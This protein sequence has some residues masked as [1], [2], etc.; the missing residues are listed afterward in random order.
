LSG[1]TTS[2]TLLGQVGQNPTNEAA[3]KRFV[4]LYAPM[5]YQWILRRGAKPEDAEDLTQMVFQRL[6]H[7]MAEF[8]YDR[9][10]GSFKGWLRTVTTNVWNDFRRKKSAV[11][12]QY[13][14][15]EKVPAANG[16]A[17]DFCWDRRS[18]KGCEHLR[19]FLI[20]ASGK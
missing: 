12:V 5:I 15:L 3:W 19:S 16:T 20:A 10:K 6:F 7:S 13:P 8:T 18:V 17:A 9:T 1:T 2:S 4:N 14:E 11:L